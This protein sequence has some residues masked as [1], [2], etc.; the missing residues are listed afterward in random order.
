[1]SRK[2]KYSSKWEKNYQKNG[3]YRDYCK[4]F[5]KSFSIDCSGISQAKSHENFKSHKSS[6]VQFNSWTRFNFSNGIATLNRSLHS[7][8]LEDKIIRGEILHFARTRAM[9]NDFKL[10]SLTPR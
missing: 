1:M 5:L 3:K 7:L 2:T 10:C 4:L 6:N 9:K 8:S